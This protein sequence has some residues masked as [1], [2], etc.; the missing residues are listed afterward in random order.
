MGKRKLTQEDRVLMHLQNNKSLTSMEAFNK[1]GITRL[2]AKIFDLRRKG[3]NI[4]SVGKEVKNRYGDTCHVAE[5]ILMKD[6][7]KNID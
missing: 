5:Y 2:S 7:I 6:I 4:A 3:Y 1:Y